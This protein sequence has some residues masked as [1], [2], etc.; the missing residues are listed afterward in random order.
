MSRSMTILLVLS[1]AV[2]FQCTSPSEEKP[3]NREPVFHISHEPSRSDKPFSDAVQVGDLFFLTGQIGLDHFSGELVEGG[4]TPE[5]RQTLENIKAVLAHHDMSMDDVVKAT[6][7]LDTIA[8]FA[9]FNSVYITYFP[10]KPARTTFAAE[11]LARNA[12]IE[13]EVVAIKH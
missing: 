2:I 11:S 12:R 4:I 10:K 3:E 1:S 5:T 7:I 13:I 6:V 8:D 9:E